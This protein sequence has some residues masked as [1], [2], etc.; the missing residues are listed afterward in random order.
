MRMCRLKNE[1]ERAGGLD[2]ETMGGTGEARRAC[3]WD[4]LTKLNMLRQSTG[5]FLRIQW[6]APELRD[7]EWLPEPEPGLRIQ[8]RL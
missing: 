2:K 4:I 3:P 8:Q 5:D 6:L 1:E 7:H